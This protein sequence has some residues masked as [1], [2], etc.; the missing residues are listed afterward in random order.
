MKIGLALGGGGVRGFAHILV[1]KAMDDL[2]LKPSIIAGT[3]MGAIIGAMYASGL[4]GDLLLK[5]L[6]DYSVQKNDS[7]RDIY[8]KR[9]N[10]LE[11]MKIFS[12]ERKRGGIIETKGL[13]K[14][15]FEEI[16][17]DSFE[18]LEIPLTVIAAD[19]WS[20]EEV[21]FN[22]GQL[23]PAIQASMAVP[24]VFAPV[25]LAGRVLIDGGVVN[26]VPYDHVA[27]HCDVTIAVNVGGT[28]YPDETPV[29]NVM[30][31][32]LGTIGV[33]QTAMLTKKLQQHPPDIYIHPEIK[34]IRMMDFTGIEQVLEQSKPA[35]NQLIEALKRLQ[36]E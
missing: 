14:L 1:L 36:K 25:S 23:L 33:M 19:Y 15:L 24:G 5:L 7:L 21:V 18:D 34:G 3:S 30:E 26:L 16:K 9:D 22:K 28:R 20:A 29:P 10:L 2:G 13:F 11:L 32:L 4:R 35:V 17:Y 27:P 6:Q 12:L 31:S 8:N